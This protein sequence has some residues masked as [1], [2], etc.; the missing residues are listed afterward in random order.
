MVKKQD[1]E[2]FSLNKEVGIKES[3]N[4]IVC[5]VMGSFITLVV[6]WL[7]KDNGVVINSMGTVKYTTIFQLLSIKNSTI[8]ISI[9]FQRS[10]LSMRAS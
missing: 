10:G 6:N 3:G 5:K 8:Q 2:S 4:R 9:N 1:G 7:I